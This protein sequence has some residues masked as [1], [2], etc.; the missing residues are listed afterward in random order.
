MQA[1]IDAWNKALHLSL[2]TVPKV[3]DVRIDKKVDQ[4]LS[5]EILR[6]KSDM[7]CLSLA[8][9]HKNLVRSKEIAI[10]SNQKHC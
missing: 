4:R 10:E 7:H 1:A 2:I 6:V 8:P 9:K 3:A 5:D